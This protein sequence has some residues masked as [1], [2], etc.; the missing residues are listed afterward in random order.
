VLA[1]VA[2]RDADFETKGTQVDVSKGF[3]GVTLK[4]T[5]FFV[6]LLQFSAL[7]HLVVELLA[8]RIDVFR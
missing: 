2:L 1:V 5:E 7:L 8:E 6:S 3:E 4:L